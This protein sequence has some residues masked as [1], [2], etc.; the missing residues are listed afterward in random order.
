[1]ADR[2]VAALNVAHFKKLMATET[3]EARLRVLQRLLTEEEA[4]VVQIK[5]AERNGTST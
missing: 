2:T 3:D 1:M 5:L 4:K